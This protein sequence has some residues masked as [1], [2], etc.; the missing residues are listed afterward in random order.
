M[1]PLTS[2]LVAAR[3]TGVRT[4]LPGIEVDAIDRATAFR[5]QLEVV[6]ELGTS[7][8]GWKVAVLADDDVIAAPIITERLIRLPTSLPPSVYGLGGVECEVAF[9]IARTPIATRGEFSRDEILASM[10]S[11]HAAMEVLD[12]RWTMGLTSPRNAMVADLL[13]NG[14]LVIGEPVDEW[15]HQ[16]FAS[17]RVALEVNGEVLIER[18][19]GHASGDLIG[20][21]A[22]LANHL[23]ERGQVLRRGQFVTTGSFT[24]VHFAAPGDEMTIRFQGFPLLTV[25]FEPE[26]QD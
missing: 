16:N 23:A 13:A 1:H 17:L 19:G 4:T 2:A 25:A 5:V 12:S 22:L 8:A 3:T 10:G 14:A 6:E 20:W 24:G 21:V 18:E 7:I 11:A 15:R 9:E 26:P